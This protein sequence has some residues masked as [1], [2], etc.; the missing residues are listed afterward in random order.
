MSTTNFDFWSRDNAHEQEGEAIKP[1]F[2]S[3]LGI[4]ASFRLVGMT[5]LLRGLLTLSLTSMPS[6]VTKSLF[7]FARA[8][9]Q[10]PRSIFACCKVL[11]PRE[12]GF[13][14]LF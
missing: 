9:F 4:F 3:Q 10:P 1:I 12:A 13:S 5:L 7:F 8:L 11:L 2:T 14:F 6:C